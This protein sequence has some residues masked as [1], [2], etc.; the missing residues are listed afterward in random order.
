V[1][2]TRIV[3]QTPRGEGVTKGN[4]SLTKEE[5]EIIASICQH[6]VRRKIV[7]LFLERNQPLYYNEILSI[8]RASELTIGRHVAV[9]EISRI[10]ICEPGFKASS[11]KTMVRCYSVNPVYL[12][13]LKKFEYL[14]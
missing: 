4:T 3:R 14:L 10:L 1:L 6:P 13:F 2:P 12:G 9:L 7:K 11:D 8:L 5:A